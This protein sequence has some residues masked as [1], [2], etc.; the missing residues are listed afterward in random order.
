MT[1]MLTL[2]ILSQWTKVYSKV[3]INL[4]RMLQNRLASL[5]KQ[6]AC[7]QA[8]WSAAVCPSRQLYSWAAMGPSSSPVSSCGSGV[9]LGLLGYQAGPAWR[10]RS[11]SAWAS[12]HLL[13][14]LGGAGMQPQ[15]PGKAG[16]TESVW[17]ASV[18]AIQTLSPPLLTSLLH[19]WDMLLELY[20]FYDA[21]FYISLF[22]RNPVTQNRNLAFVGRGFFWCTPSN[23]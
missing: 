1:S 12:P 14:P 16:S 19:G 8:G 9:S 7:C 18:S 3:S 10:K 5:P 2:F 23:S 21:F 6:S 15:A 17:P 13:C 20:R 11:C 4:L 22:N